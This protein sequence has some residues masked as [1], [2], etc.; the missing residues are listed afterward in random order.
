MSTCMYVGLC[1]Y[2]CMHACMI[3]F[4]FSTQSFCGCFVNNSFVMFPE[5]VMVICNHVSFI[6]GR[7]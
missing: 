2:V 6:Q 1:M 5:H 7:S 3:N 4:T